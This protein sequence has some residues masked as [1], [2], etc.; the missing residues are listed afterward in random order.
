M[1][2]TA[3]N[4]LQ[5]NVKKSKVSLLCFY[6]LFFLS[7]CS[8]EEIQCSAD[9]YAMNTL[10]SISAWGDE[11]KEAIK[12]GER[13]IYSLDA[14]FSTTRSTSE[15]SQL[16]QGEGEWQTVSQEVADVVSFALDIAEKTDS[17]FD[18]TIYPIVQAWGFTQSEY[19]VPSQKELDTLLEF[20][21]YQWVELDEETNALRMP[22]EVQL[23]FG[24]LAKGYAVDMLVDIFQ[25]HH[26]RSGMLALGGNIYALG[27]KT[28]GSLWNIGIQN[29]YG[30]G[31]IGVLQVADKAV[32]TSGGYQRYFTDPDTGTTYCHIIDPRTGYPITEGLASVTI[33]S[34]SGM[35]GDALST[36][37]FVMGLEDATDFWRT[38]G[39]FDMILICS[40]GNVHITSGIADSF[41]LSKG[42]T[43]GEIVVIYDS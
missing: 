18:P 26:I 36:A 30:G 38:Y 27:Q 5:A 23:D 17:A 34:E 9:I 37:I 3:S 28:D 29:P 33:V 2:V 8:N 32:I 41:S 15:I 43:L 42:Y 22:Q 24:A 1:N 21:D 40:Q 6:S 11:S 12:E 20:V 39:D 13:F 4:F 16:N 31:S 7:S 19:Q 35:L 14:T 10:I 25:D